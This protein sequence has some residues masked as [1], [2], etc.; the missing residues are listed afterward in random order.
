MHMLGWTSVRLK[1]ETLTLTHSLNRYY[2][3]TSLSPFIHH[4][5]IRLSHHSIPVFSVMRVSLVCNFLWSPY[6]SEETRLGCQGFG[7]PVSLSAVCPLPVLHLLASFT[8]MSCLPRTSL[9]RLFLQKITRGVFTIRVFLCFGSHP[10]I[11]VL[12]FDWGL[13]IIRY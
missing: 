8:N 9:F 10:F 2:S 1:A 12:G 3:L 4:V 6:G 11:S 13:I 7:Y 5:S